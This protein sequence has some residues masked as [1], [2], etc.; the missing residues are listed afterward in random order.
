MALAL[1][2]TASLGPADFPLQQLLKDPEAART[3]DYWRL[4]EGR[5]A[6]AIPP[7]RTLS[8][9]TMGLK[10]GAPLTRCFTDA[11]MEVQAGLKGVESAAS[12]R[13][14]REDR[15]AAA[16]AVRRLDQALAALMAGGS[17]GD[18]SLDRAIR[19]FLDRSK[20]DKSARGRELAFRAAKD[21]AIRRAFG[22]ESLLG[23]L[24]PLA[25]L[26]TNRRIAARACRIDADNVAWIKREVRSRGW[27]EISRYGRE[28]EKDAWLLAQHADE[29]IAFQ[30]EILARLD[31]LRTKGET[32]PK[33]YAYLY[34]RVAINNGRPQRYGTQGGCRDGKRFTFP[35]EASANVDQL[36]AEVGLTTLAEYNSR[37]TCRD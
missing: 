14:W 10:E 29:D 2:V 4:R 30:T 35:L 8:Y 6:E 28:A 24:S 33:N 13:Q 1:A 17:S 21:Q 15:D 27:F 25:M 22:N 5:G 9:A 3:F 31:A 7:L 18:A 36:R 23:P 37:F 32:D 19:P 11:E 20:T 26:L 12:A 16:G 34:D